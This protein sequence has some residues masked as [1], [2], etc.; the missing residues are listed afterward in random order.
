MAG[1][2]APTGISPELA[3]V[4]P[5]LAASARRLLPLP[6]RHVVERAEPQAPPPPGR[7]RSA[8][9]FVAV[10]CVVLA[11][12]AGVQRESSGTRPQALA[13]IAGGYTAGSR[14]H[15]NVTRGSH[16]VSGLKVSLACTGSV[17]LPPLPVERDL[18]FSYRG[19]VRGSEA[20]AALDLR[21]T[22][23]SAASATVVVHASGLGCAGTPTRFV[24]KAS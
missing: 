15:F 21:G 7:L 18:S 23:T 24:A 22:F 14:L 20:P 12:V 11:A 17:A 10:V 16:H 13:G 9:V 3:L 1:S 4:D 2:N 5:D 8:I 6:V 19:D